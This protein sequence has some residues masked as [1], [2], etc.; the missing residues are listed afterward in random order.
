[1]PPDQE[2]GDFPGRP[3]VGTKAVEQ[4]WGAVIPPVSAGNR[5]SRRFQSWKKRV[6]AFMKIQHSLF[7]ISPH[8]KYSY[9]R[10]K[11]HSPALSEE[12]LTFPGRL[13]Y[14]G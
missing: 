2:V 9:C 4:G 8:S 13:S 14:S 12:N 3:A 5:Q 6:S 11:P 1:M 10:L 7:L